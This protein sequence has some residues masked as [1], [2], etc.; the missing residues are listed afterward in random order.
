LPNPQAEGPPLV[1]CP[2][3]FIQY[4]RIWLQ[5]HLKKKKTSYEHGSSNA[6]TVRPEDNEVT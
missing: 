5:Y 1:G 6:S 2:R 4:I 3:V